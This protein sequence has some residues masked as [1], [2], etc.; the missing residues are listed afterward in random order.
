MTPSSERQLGT[1]LW[2]ILL[3]SVIGL[4]AASF[5]LYEHVVYANGLETGPAICSIS[6]YIDCTKVNTSAWSTFF[7]LPLGA[8]GIFFYTV[9]IAIT[10]VA[11]VSGAVSRTQALAVT[12]LASAGAS[13]ASIALF[14]ISHFI[15]GALC[16]MCLTLY[17][18]NF[19]LFGLTALGPWR[20]RLIEGLR[21]GFD[22]ILHFFGVT[23]L[24]M[25]AR[26]VGL[27]VFARTSLIALI[28]FG[29]AVAQLPDAMLSHLRKGLPPERDPL[30][31][32]QVAAWHDAPVV[33][34]VVID[35]AGNLSDM[36]QGRV[37]APISLVEFADFECPGCRRMY[38]TLHTVLKEYEGSYT[39]VFKNY[40]LDGDCNPTITRRFH[41]HACTAAFFTRCAGEQGK[42]RESVDY[43]FT[44]PALDDPEGFSKEQMRD[45]LIQKGSS[46]LGLDAAALTQCIESKRYLNK[47]REDV[48]E[49]RRLELAATPSLWINGKLLKS[50]NPAVL[51]AVLN[52]L[53]APKTSGTR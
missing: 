11:A 30:I 12:L 48:E 23:V 10:G 3:L 1:I 50:S 38:K 29:W 51:R 41:L 49:G 46:Q 44:E 52:S 21:T 26:T 35:G 6:A 22:T 39:F 4:A 32:E 25:P 7:G 14:S 16:I 24:L 37:D 28:V 43:L 36:R 42:M 53:Q 33:T 8:Y 18:V 5:A 47:I 9:L 13:L 45:T 19:A 31:K 40:P 17:L 15:I 34:L 20:G 27:G 2:L